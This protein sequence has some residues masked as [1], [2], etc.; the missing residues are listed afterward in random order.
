MYITSSREPTLVGFDMQCHDFLVAVSV[1]AIRTTEF[2]HA[3]RYA[4]VPV[5]L[6]F[7]HLLGTTGR[8]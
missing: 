6:V 1:V 8:E 3:S 4:V 5:L 2:A 7:Q